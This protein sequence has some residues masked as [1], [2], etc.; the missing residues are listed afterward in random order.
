METQVCP[1]RILVSNLP[2]E[3]PEEKVLDKL[4]IHFSRTRNGGG[5]VENKDMLHDSG[6]VV[7]IFLDDNSKLT[8]FIQSDISVH[9]AWGVFLNCS[10]LFV[11]SC[12][13]SLWQT[14]SW[15]RLW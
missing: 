9:D 4:D 15:C 2:K 5:E 7:I 12:Q 8:K 10:F 3:E 1:R 14:R 11:F 13:R 6:T